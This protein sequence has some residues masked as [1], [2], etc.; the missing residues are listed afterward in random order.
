MKS[1][2]RRVV[3]GALVVP[4]QEPGRPY[5]SAQML[6]AGSIVR[7]VK[8]VPSAITGDTSERTVRWVDM[9]GRETTGWLAKH[10]A[11]AKTKETKLYLERNS[12][13]GPKDWPYAW[14]HLRHM[15][16]MNEGWDAKKWI[17]VFGGSRV[18]LLHAVIRELGGKVP[19][20]DDPLLAISRTLR[21]ILNKEIRMSDIKKARKSA[22][23]TKS[24][25]TE[26]AD[27]TAVA[28][29]S[30]KKNGSKSTTKKVK[31]K[32]STK[33]AA[34]KNDDDGARAGRK[35]AF[36]TK[37]IVRLVKENP[38]REG[39]AGYRNWKLYKKGMTYEQ[40]LDAGGK[41][42]CLAMDIKRGNVKLVKA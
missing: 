37:R 21:L 22:K 30:S 6:P 7:L 18:P 9:V 27:V 19:V 31:V 13:L 25:A 35:S 40:F 20:S 42:G 11:L 29:K 14:D 34:A 32:A 12:K 5:W 28:T 36:A 26:K 39:S 33:R 38:R 10:V 16:S 24:A 41:R 23:S 2:Y 15:I 4:M 17:A 3:K 8:P 1:Q